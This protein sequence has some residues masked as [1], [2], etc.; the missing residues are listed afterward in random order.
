MKQ[1]VLL[2]LVVSS[3]EII[4]KMDCQNTPNW[5]KSE[6]LIHQEK[7]TL[8]LFFGQNVNGHICWSNKDTKMEILVEKYSIILDNADDPFWDVSIEIFEL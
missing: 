3:Y 1:N 4:V 5:Q 2:S 7:W 6:L 8:R